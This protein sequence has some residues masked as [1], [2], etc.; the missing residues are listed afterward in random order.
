[1]AGTPLEAP[2]AALCSHL[3]AARVAAA[4]HIDYFAEP[5]SK[6]LLPDLP[7]H[8][9]SY[10]RT[11]GARTHACAL[12][13][14]FFAFRDALAPAFLRPYR[15]L[16]CVPAV[17]DLDGVLVKSDW[18]RERGWRTFKRPGADAFL[19]HMA[20][21]YEVVVFTDQLATYGDPIIE[22]LDPGR[23]AAPQSAVICAHFE[24]ILG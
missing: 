14:F 8:A 17:L 3:L 12:L 21:Y 9:A 1:M 15:S 2:V 7:P 22:R 13:R 23:C 11:L 16:R 6:K 18:N 5:S 10:M 24:L 4:E 20:Q 19:K